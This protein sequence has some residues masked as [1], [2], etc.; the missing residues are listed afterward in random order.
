M[1]KL[2]L[3]I[4]LPMALLAA[5]CSSGSGNNS[6]SSGGGGI[7]PVSAQT[8]YSTS[9]LSG[10]YSVSWWSF[11]GNAQ[12]GNASYYSAIGTIQFNGAGNISGGTI[13]EYVEGNAPYPCAFTV[14]GTYAIQS[15]ALGTATLN[16]SSSTKGCPASDT[17][18]LALAAADGGAVVQMT[19]TDNYAI[20]NGNAVKQ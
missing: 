3:S 16:L 4:A 19:R 15:T 5:S 11:S 6:S 12:G 18:Q 14:A 7:Q 17:W 9:S 13:T 8:T 1:R 2:L 20:A 10:T